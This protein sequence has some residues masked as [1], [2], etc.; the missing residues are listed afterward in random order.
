M[1]K[2]GLTTGSSGDPHPYS[3]T[4]KLHW[5]VGACDKPSAHLLEYPV[6]WDGEKAEWKKDEYTKLQGKTP[7]R[8]VYANANGAPVYCG[9]MTH[10]K[11][12]KEHKGEA[13]FVKCE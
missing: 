4:D 11:V 1:Q 3:N 10:S 7:I 9:V 2:A 8:V 6:F 13:F 5:G 12:T